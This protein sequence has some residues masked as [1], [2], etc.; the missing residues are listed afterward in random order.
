[1]SDEARAL[2][3]YKTALALIETKGS[4]MSVGL[5][6][7]KEYRASSL[8]V[9]Y[10]PSPGWLD[11]WNVRKVL[12]IKRWNGALRIIRYVPGPWEQELNKLAEQSAVSSKL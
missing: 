11:V 4:F 8:I 5:I 12:S 9:R 6:R 7:I 1:M 2:Q 10:Q 3:L